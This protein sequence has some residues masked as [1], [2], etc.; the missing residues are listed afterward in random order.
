MITV[1]K[2][3]LTRKANEFPFRLGLFA[4]ME[5]DFSQPKLS[6]VKALMKSIS[7]YIFWAITLKRSRFVLGIISKRWDRHNCDIG[8]YKIF[9]IV[10][11]SRTSFFDDSS[12]SRSKIF[13]THYSW[14]SSDTSDSCYQKNRHLSEIVIWFQCDT[15]P[16][17]D[18]I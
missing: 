11:K 10:W 7:S 6:L 17:R 18:M 4:P 3:L 5:K 15:F 2:S 13:I 16:I 1:E 8:L 9:I 14:S 12:T